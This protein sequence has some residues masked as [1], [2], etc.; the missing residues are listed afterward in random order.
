M[1]YMWCVYYGLQA[2]SSSS[3]QLNSMNSTNLLI[4]YLKINKKNGPTL[5]LFQ[6]SY[7][8]GSNKKCL[9]ASGALVAR[10]NLPKIFIS[11]PP[12]LP[13]CFVDM[14][15]FFGR[16]HNYPYLYLYQCLILVWLTFADKWQ[17]FKLYY[18]IMFGCLF[19]IS[20]NFY[21]K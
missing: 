8:F 6:V 5:L 17:S 12:L 11:A 9:V 16:I 18:L 1:T 7:T 20:H 14:Q 15:K 4:H 2:T 19:T 13:I 21:L 3:V 10:Q